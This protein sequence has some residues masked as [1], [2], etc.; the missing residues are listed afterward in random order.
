MLS[1]S[2]LNKLLETKKATTIETYKRQLKCL[3]LKEINESTLK[4]TVKGI[5]DEFMKKGYSTPKVYINALLKVYQVSEHDKEELLYLKQEFKRICDESDDERRQKKQE[6]QADGFEFTW[7]DVKECYEKMKKIYNEKPTLYNLTNWFISAIY[8]DDS[9]GVKRTIDIINLTKSN[10]NK[11]VIEFTANKNN[12]HYKSLPLSSHIL[13]PL[14]LLMSKNQ[15]ETLIL[16]KSGLKYS[17]NNFLH[18]LHE[19]FGSNI[20]SQYLRRLWASYH[21]SKN[22]TAKDLLRQA[23]ELNHSIEMHLTDYV[24]EYTTDEIIWGEKHRFKK[25]IVY[26]RIF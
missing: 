2:I 9:F 18:R 25:V 15:K 16:T 11:D 8:S 19:I 4:G 10:I 1:Q 13:T 21:Y 22:P 7:G 20:D 5:V 26:K 24:S 3:G 23:Y 14:L 12:F 17:T 6:K